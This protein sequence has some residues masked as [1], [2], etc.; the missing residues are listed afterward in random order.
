MTK[1]VNVLFPVNAAAM[2]FGG[3]WVLYLLDYSIS[4]ENYSIA[5]LAAFLVW[6]VANLKF[7]ITWS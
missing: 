3:K 6:I 4:W 2:Y 7:T 1:T 5:A